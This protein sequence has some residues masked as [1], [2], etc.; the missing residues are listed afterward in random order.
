ML[1]LYLFVFIVVGPIGHYVSCVERVVLCCVP[2]LIDCHHIGT[3]EKK[4]G[5]KRKKLNVIDF[6]SDVNAS[7]CVT[8]VCLC[9]LF[10]HQ[11]Q[12]IHSSNYR[13]AG[14]HMD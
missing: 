12:S 14:T 7:R 10:L 5:K 4:I 6:R 8:R 1:H 13:A 2:H 3:K 11:Q 9:V